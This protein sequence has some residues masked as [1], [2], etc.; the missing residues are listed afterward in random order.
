MILGNRLEEY[1]L[2]GEV[3]ADSGS[4][5]Y[6]AKEEEQESIYF[7][8]EWYTP[9]KDL[10]NLLIMGIDNFGIKASSILTTIPGRQIFWHLLS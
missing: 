2:A 1:L 3:L 5:F 8:Q 9:R 7:E 6:L 10:T 4:A